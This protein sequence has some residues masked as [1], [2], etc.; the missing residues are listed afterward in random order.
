MP[1]YI[2]AE[3]SRTAKTGGI[4]GRLTELTLTSGLKEERL[5]MEPS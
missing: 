3:A 4:C 2:F 1:T 5:G